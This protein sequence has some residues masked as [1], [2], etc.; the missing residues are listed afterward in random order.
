MTSRI[1]LVCA[2]VVFSVAGTVAALCQNPEL[3]KD[4]AEE[5]VL[6]FG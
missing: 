5:G 3:G 6:R 1:G 4:L 2:V